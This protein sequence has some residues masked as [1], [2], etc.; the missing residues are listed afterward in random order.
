[1]TTVLLVRHGET[2]WNAER[3]LQGWAPVPLSARGREQARRLADALAERHDVD[4]V[5]ASDLARTVETAELLAGPLGLE[6][7]EDAAWRERDFGVLQGLGYDAFDELRPAA[8]LA[9]AGEDAVDVRPE[10]GES[11][12]DLRDRV[13]DAWAALLAE[14]GPD[15]T[16]VVVTHGGPIYLVLGHLLDRG[17]VE[18]VLGSSQ[19][20]CAVNEIRVE[21][22]EA[23]VRRENDTS[24]RDA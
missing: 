6:V 18:A 13:L 20:N 11:L 10:R 16:H 1:M 2:G 7:V 21:R 22:G 23:T 19:A 9:V 5:V 3:R 17:I 4:R 12:A 15:E 24:L 8:S 14:A